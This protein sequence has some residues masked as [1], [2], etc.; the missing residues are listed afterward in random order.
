MATRVLLADDHTIVRQAVKL[1][2]ERE[3][4]EVVGEAADGHAAV[5]QARDLQPDVVVLDLMMPLLN[6]LDAAL[7]IRQQSPRIPAILLT[8]RTDEES[9]LKAL[10]AGLKACVLKSHD[11]AALVQAIRQAVRGHVFVDPAISRTVVA[12]YRAA[13]G[14]VKNPLTPRERHVLQLIAEGKRTRE[15]AEILCVSVKTAESHRANIMNKLD[16]RETAGLVRYALRS[17]LCQL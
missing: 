11:V 7:E 15:V 2:L 6:G 10:R 14:P 13:T 12:A 5:R 17:G 3:G 9:V 16:I 4:F 1:L 8:S